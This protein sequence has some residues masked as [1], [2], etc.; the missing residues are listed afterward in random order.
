[1]KYF[2]SI[3][4]TFI[5]ALA[6]CFIPSLKSSAAVFP[7]ISSSEQEGISTNSITLKWT[8][9]N[10]V[11][12]DIE[13][14]GYNDD[15]YRKVGT[16]TETSYTIGGLEGGQVYSFRITG[17]N[18]DS[19]YTDSSYFEAKTMIVDPKVKQDSWYHY[20]K[21]ATIIWDRQ[22]AAD[23]YEVVWYNPKGKAVKKET[24]Q[25]YDSYNTLRKISNANIYTAKVRAFQTFGGKSY[26]SNW[27]EIK[28][29][30]QSFIKKGTKLIS[31]G[32]KKNLKIKW[33]KQAGA[34][35]YD[36]YVGT[37]RSKKSFSKVKSVGKNT[38]SISVSKLKKKSLKKNKYYVY[39]ITKTKHKGKTNKSGLV[40]CWEVNK[41]NAYE[42]YVD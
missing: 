34:T 3:I 12:Y 10:C 11:S 35:G 8:A 23:G 26:T 17:N 5:L 39:V 20:A 13:I 14:R 31:K 32:G 28:V 9:E 41:N 18:P 40:Y 29:F 33:T 7:N 24:L 30:E 2:K 19:I 16:T 37:S 6:I 21:S 38:T 25:K 22:S 42:T 1:M 15:E 4:A 27:S 36:I